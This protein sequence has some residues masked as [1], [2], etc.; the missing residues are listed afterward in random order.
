ML[1]SKHSPLAPLG[2]A[3]FCLCL[4]ACASR[5]IE[6]TSAVAPQTWASH[7]AAAAAIDTWTLTGRLNIRQGN[8]SDTVNLN[9]A[10]QQANFDINLSGT[11]GLGAVHLQG[12]PTF[13]TLEK[14]GE[15][16][17]VLSSLDELTQ[18]MLGY[19]F[20]AGHLLWW[21]RGLP[22]P[23]MPARPAW[24]EAGLL[25]TLSQTDTRGS[26]WSLSFDRYDTTMALPLPGRIRLQQN[27]VQLT[28]LINQWQLPEQAP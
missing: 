25:A 22:A 13:A 8:Q 16:T 23:G 5:T 7:V 21:V 18:E 12:T 3:L 24:N 6:P 17:R 26:A 19:A 1:L 27:S 15:E 20:P 11:L 4:G 14:A 28:F 9:W 10:Q 2:A